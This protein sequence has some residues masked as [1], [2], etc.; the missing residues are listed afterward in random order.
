[1]PRRAATLSE[2]LDYLE[3]VPLEF[4]AAPS[5]VATDSALYVELPVEEPAQGE[6]P[7]PP[8]VETLVDRLLSTQ[9][10][11][12]LFLS[13]HV[14][15]GKSTQVNKL[16]A[17]PRITSAFSVIPLRIEAE[18]V[19]ILDTPLLLVLLC[20]AVHHF[21]HEHGLL[22]KEATW[23]R[24]FNDF[25]ARVLNDGTQNLPT[26]GTQIEVNV[27]F[28]KLRQELKFNEHRRR[29]LREIGETQQTLLTDLI[30]QLT[31]D[32]Q[33]GLT[34]QHN[35]RSLLL[36]VDDLDKVR[37]RDQ[38]NEI[39]DRN[40]VFLTNLPFHV[41][42]TVPTGV[43]FGPS[44]LDVRR[45]LEHLYPVRALDKA[46]RTFDPEKAFIP[47]ADAFFR[48]ALDMRVEPALFDND[49]VRLATIYSGGVLR[50]F[51]RLLRTAV[52]LARHHGRTTVDG[53][54]LKSIVRDERRRESMGLLAQDYEALRAIHES[55]ALTSEEGRRYL[56]E[57]RVLE[58][59]NDKTWYEVT[60][61]L[62]KLLEPSGAA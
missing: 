30:E 51:F 52:R 28:V 12:V 23:H 39:F 35:G 27:F 37:T 25:V 26:A 34:K 53:G 58:C 47:H 20:S 32:V 8:L 61:I 31:D 41:L 14:G 33:K 49:A 55:H 16:A 45:S 10:R 18:H 7:P 46:P 1:M 15:S 43:V 62:W 4:G 44:R 24:V 50:D 59:Y 6:L 3:L 9:Q 56:D 29:L 54:V 60:P 21:G 17:D 57:G 22:S 42:Y 11:A 2:S 40:L 5:S 13:G 38:Q 19:P 48:R 36:L